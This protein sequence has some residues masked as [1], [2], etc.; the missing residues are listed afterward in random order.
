MAV[1]RGGHWVN[2]GGTWGRLTGVGEGLKVVGPEV[3]SRT[4]GP[5]GASLLAGKDWA[6]HKIQGW[7]PDFIPEVLNRAVAAQILPIDDVVSRDTARRMAQEEGIFVGLAAGATVAAAREVAK[8]AADGEGIL[9]V[10][11]GTGEGYW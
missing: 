3:K 7:T 5:A 9:A 10:L 4:C 1:T 2:G 11:A 8:S 6:P